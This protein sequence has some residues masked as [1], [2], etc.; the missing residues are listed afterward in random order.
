M[1]S[2]FK[3]K[4][5]TPMMKAL[6]GKQANLPQHLK[7]KI[8][9]APETAKKGS[10][11][12]KETPVKSYG[13]KTASPMKSYGSKKKSPVMK[14]DPSP[15]KKRI[16]VEYIPEDGSEPYMMDV[17]EGAPY[18][19]L[20]VRMAKENYGDDYK[21]NL[22]VPGGITRRGYTKDTDPFAS[23]LS[24]LQVA[25]RQLADVTNRPDDYGGGSNA[26]AIAD[27][28]RNKVDR[29]KRGKAKAPV[30]SYGSKK[31]SPVMK[32]QISQKAAERKASKGKG[33]ITKSYGGKTQKSEFVK[34]TREG[35]KEA[36]KTGMVSSKNMKKSTPIK[37]MG[38]KAL[39]AQR[40]KK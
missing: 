14:K 12:K 8:L 21:G 34:F 16:S 19:K 24:E 36:K 31:K 11:G 2:P 37:K 38:V 4:P 15:K 29:L 22:S 25:E 3:M 6:V 20:A 26:K 1:A 30:K 39:K 33:M 17:T 40:G 9:A 27:N 35:R 13:S 5:K 18:H 10:P 28:Y 32:K 23:G 7:E